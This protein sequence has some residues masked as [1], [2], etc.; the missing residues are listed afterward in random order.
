MST[1]FCYDENASPL[2]AY[3]PGPLSGCQKFLCADPEGGT[4][5]L[6]PPENHKNI[7]F[8]GNIGA[9]PLQNHKAYNPTFS[10]GPPSA[11]QRNAI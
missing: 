7:V 6:D 8:L 3:S 2:P 11:R 9:D 1:L 4:G 10:V 5:G